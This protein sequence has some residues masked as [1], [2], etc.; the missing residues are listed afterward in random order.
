MS[1]YVI[2]HHQQD[3]NQP[4]VNAW[5]NDQLIEAIQ[6]TREI[7]KLCRGA[8]E[9]GELVYV[10]RC[11]WGE[12]LPAISCAAEVEAVAEI[13]KATALVRFANPSQINSVP[14]Q[15]PIKGQNFY[16]A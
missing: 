16:V 5:L 15:I 8:K 6:T 14:P 2:V 3:E 13:D 10:H 11:G 1:L 7:G 4:W 9:R 12:C